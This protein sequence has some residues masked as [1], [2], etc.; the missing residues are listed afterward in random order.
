MKACVGCGVPFPPN[1]SR[2]G[3][4]FH[5]EACEHRAVQRRYYRRYRERLLHKKRRERRQTTRRAELISARFEKLP[6]ERKPAFADAL[7]I[8]S[9][10]DWRLRVVLQRAAIMAMVTQFSSLI[11]EIGGLL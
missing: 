4:R 8:R 1:P 11:S 10:K 9:Q 7:V 2:P 6:D 3:Q 5:D